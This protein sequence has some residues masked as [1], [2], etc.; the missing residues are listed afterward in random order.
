[1]G[2]NITLRTLT[3]LWT[4][5]IDQ[6]HDRLHETGLIGSLRWWYEALVRGLGGYACD[7]TSE[8]RCP[9]KAGKHCAACELFGCTGWARKFRLQVTDTYDKIIQDPLIAPNTEFVLH[10]IELRQ[11]DDAEKWLS[12]QTIRIAATYGAVGGKTTLKPQKGVVGQDYGI[13][14]WLGA[15]LAKKADNI[16]IFL[17]QGRDLPQ[18]EFPNLK[19]F[20]FIHGAFLSRLRMNPLLGLDNS[21]DP[22]SSPEDWQKFLQ[23]RRGSKTK[24]AVS[25]KLFSFRSNGGRIWGYAKDA[26][27][28]DTVIERI[29]Q[30]LGNGNY[31]KKTGEEVLHEL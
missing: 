16:E 17:K 10:F 9:D 4:G 25:K 6:T 5:G 14:Q 30:Q 15:N 24:S 3:P 1:M 21:G 23:G 7:P 19:W 2:M 18:E 8:D 11:M 27:M 28:R 22:L 26:Q 31:T 20:F 12:T 13:V 29:K